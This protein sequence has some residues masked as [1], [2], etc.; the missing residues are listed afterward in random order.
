MIHVLE[1]HIVAA[2]MPQ[3]V[4]TELKENISFLEKFL[5]EQL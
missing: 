4:T 3:T 5:K 1:L 2:N